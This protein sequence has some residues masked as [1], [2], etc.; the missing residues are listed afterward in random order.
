MVASDAPHSQTRSLRITLIGVAGSGKTTVGELLAARLACAFLDADLLHTSACRKQMH[1]GMPLSSE[2][3]NQWFDRVLAAVGADDSIV[4]ACSA[5][6]RAHRDRL[7]ALGSRMVLLEVSEPELERRLEARSRHFFDPD[8]LASQIDAFEAP[9]PEEGIV[10]I[11]ASAPVVA[12]V[13][14]IV[15]ALDA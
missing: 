8:L 14:D 7:R 12:V 4:L 2:Q 13:D 9:A 15:K 1:R 11:D 6:R 5:V 10:N 3:R